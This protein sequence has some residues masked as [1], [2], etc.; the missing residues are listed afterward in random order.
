MRTGL[1][2]D[3]GD[4]AY[5]D[6]YMSPDWVQ[7]MLDMP[8]AASPGSEFNY[9][10]GCSHLLSALLQQTTGMNPRDFAEKNLFKPLGIENARWESN[11]AGIPIGGWGL[12][13]TPRDG[14]IG[15]PVSTQ[16]PVG[17]AADRLCPMGGE[18]H[19]QPYGDGRRSGLRVPVVDGSFPGSVYGLRAIWPNDHGDPRLG[20]GD[21]HHRSNGK[22]RQDLP[23]CRAVYCSGSAEIAIG[24]FQSSV[25]RC[26]LHKDL[27]G[28]YRMDRIKRI[29]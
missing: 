3:E 1:D 14:K 7:H 23:A 10:S 16:R 6:L 19:A 28:I 8:M 20:A 29:I 25:H 5:R 18:R 22:P 13:L 24:A 2:W 21:R 26:G 12:Q 11:P 27:T 17:R 9:C 15:L 4:P